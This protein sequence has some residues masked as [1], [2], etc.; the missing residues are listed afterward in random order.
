MTA[1]EKAML[2]NFCSGRARL[3]SSSKDI[4]MRFKITGAPPRSKQN[5]DDYLPIAQTCFFSLS[6]PE[7]SSYEVSLYKMNQQRL[8]IFHAFLDGHCLCTGLPQQV[9]L[10]HTQYAADGCRLCDEKCRWL[11]ER[12]IEK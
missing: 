7:Y 1:E 4:T 6:L 12:E 5:P 8:P 2:V 10:R 11:G 3:P 9:A